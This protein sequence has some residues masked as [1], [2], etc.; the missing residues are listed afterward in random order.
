M[1]NSTGE[2]K[3]IPGYPGYLITEDGQLFRLVRRGSVNYDTAT[4]VATSPDGKVVLSGPPPTRGFHTIGISRLVEM[5]FGKK[6]ELA[7]LV[8]ED[9][10]KVVREHV[11]TPEEQEAQAQSFV[12]GN[13]AIDNPAVTKEMV[14]EVS[15]ARKR[16]KDAE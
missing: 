11:M 6:D 1:A 7:E 16:K 10:S 2:R 14:A 13:V 4:P 3:E 5:A 12:F 15:K 8:G 9:L